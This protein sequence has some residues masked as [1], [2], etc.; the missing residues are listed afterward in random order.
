VQE[1]KVQTRLAIPIA[2]GLIANYLLTVISLAFVGHL[3]TQELAAA[4]LGSTLYSMS[5]K[6]L[7]QGL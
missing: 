6:I 4:A 1:I 7:L 2:V 3:G 5:A